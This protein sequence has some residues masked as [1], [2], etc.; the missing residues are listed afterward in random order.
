M[1]PDEYN[2]F[3]FTDADYNKLK[4]ILENAERNPPLK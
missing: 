4:Y 3:I 1:L 2:K